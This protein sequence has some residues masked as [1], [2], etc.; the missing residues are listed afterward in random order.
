MKSYSCPLGEY[1]YYLY[2]MIIDHKYDISKFGSTYYTRMEIYYFS[3]CITHGGYNYINMYNLE[4]RTSTKSEEIIHSNALPI[5]Q[6][7][8]TLNEL[9]DHI[10]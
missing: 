1:T 6:K 7:V 9:S 4:A 5:F 10:K 2:T 3:N 8:I